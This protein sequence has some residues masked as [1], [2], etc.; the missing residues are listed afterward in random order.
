VVP[1]SFDAYFTAAA[2]AAGALIGLL[3]VAI[4]LRPEA[5]LGANP[6]SRARALASSSFTGLVNGFFISMAAL[7]PGKNLG[8][9][10]IILGVFSLAA[11]FRLHRRVGRSATKLAVSTLTTVAF[12]AEVAVGIGL[13]V[14]PHK[15]SLVT[16]IAWITIASL[17]VALMRAWSLLQGEGMEKQTV[18]GGVPS[19]TAGG[20]QSDGG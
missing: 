7:I 12:A 15:T 9:T 17:A 19:Q 8:V 3:F 14:R 10:A 11:T 5:V 2:S 20:G 6:S 13:V 16:D 18:A 4:S 1:D